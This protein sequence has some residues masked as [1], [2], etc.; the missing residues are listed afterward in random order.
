M[1]PDV[2]KSNT[3][4]LQPTKETGKRNHFTQ[5]KLDFTPLNIDDSLKFKQRQHWESMKA[6]NISKAGSKGHQAADE[7]VWKKII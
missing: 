4:Y 6:T 1:R 7:K 2:R 3:S 5:K